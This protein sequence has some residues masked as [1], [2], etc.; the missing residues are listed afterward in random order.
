MPRVGLLGSTIASTRRR[1]ALSL[2]RLASVLLRGT[3]GLYKEA[4][5]SESHRQGCA[6]D[7]CLANTWAAALHSVHGSDRSPHIGGK[8]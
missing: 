1:G 4:P 6:L 5:E 2:F 7:C 8:V 3:I